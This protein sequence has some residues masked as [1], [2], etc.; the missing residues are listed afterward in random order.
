MK[1]ICGLGNPGNKYKFTRHNAG[2][3]LL[4]WIGEKENLT[5]S[6]NKKFNAMAYKGR[7]LNFDAIFVKPLTY[8]NL[9]GESLLSSLSFYKLKSE[10]LVLVHDDVDI[11][12]ETVKIKSGG[13]TAG[14]RG[15]KSIVSKIGNSFTRLRI[16]VGRPPGHMDTSDYVLQSFSDAEIEKLPEILDRAY[17]GVNLLLRFGPEE[18]MNKFN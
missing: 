8:M 2:F 15:L 6:K 3:L 13:G 1:L 7:Y 11:P 12:F 4:D 18:A 10:D 9:S 16:G 5:F 17:E 14:H